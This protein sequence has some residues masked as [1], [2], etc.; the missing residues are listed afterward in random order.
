MIA[1]FYVKYLD[2]EQFFNYLDPQD[3][4]N[5]G[6]TTGMVRVPVWYLLLRSAIGRSFSVSSSATPPGMRPGEPCI[7]LR[8]I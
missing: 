1:H 7:I 6:T 5:L 4:D 2:P 3:S 8:S